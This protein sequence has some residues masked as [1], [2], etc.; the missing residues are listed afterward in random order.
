VAAVRERLRQLVGRW[1]ATPYGVAL[2]LTWSE[3]EP[4]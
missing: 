3:R 1:K 4:R 2:E